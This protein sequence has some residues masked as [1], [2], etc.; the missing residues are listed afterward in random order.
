MTFCKTLVHKA[1]VDCRVEI[2]VSPCNDNPNPYSND[3]RGHAASQR[4]AFCNDNL[5]FTAP[6]FAMI[7]FLSELLAFL[8][9]L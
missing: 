6:F 3:V 2:K 1:H 4:D 9:I 8:F 5:A 7:T